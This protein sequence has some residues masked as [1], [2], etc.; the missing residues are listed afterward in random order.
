MCAEPIARRSSFERIWEVIARIPKGR[1][2]NYGQIARIAGLG[3][4][5]RLVGYA[6]H[7]APDDMALPWHRVINAQGRISFPRGSEN[8]R[9][10]R[11]LL[12]AEGIVFL[13]DRVDFKSCR[14]N[15]ETDEWP[16]EYLEPERLDDEAARKLNMD[17]E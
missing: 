16:E 9:R 12:E 10:Q 2:A 17:F 15:P 11:S 8:H 7:S 4:R 3:K 5:A 1:V 14:W 13:G 6:L